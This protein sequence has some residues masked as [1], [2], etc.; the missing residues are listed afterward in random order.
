MI[1]YWCILMSPLALI[2][3]RHKIWWL[4][5]L[6][7]NQIWV[8]SLT[9]G[10]SVITRDTKVTKHPWGC[11]ACEDVYKEWLLLRLGCRDGDPVADLRCELDQSCDN[12]VTVTSGLT[13]PNILTSLTDAGSVYSLSFF[14]SHV[15]PNLLRWGHW[16]IVTALN[17]RVS[18][19][20]W[21]SPWGRIDKLS[22]NRTEQSQLRWKSC[23]N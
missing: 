10:D 2:F 4:H 22:I 7:W 17:I 11:W 19:T 21:I 5:M 20:V 9:E 18:N 14:W 23:Y 12:L 1:R 3:S 15:Q 13:W 8:T 6:W 16:Y